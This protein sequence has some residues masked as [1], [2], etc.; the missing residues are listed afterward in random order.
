MS[1]MVRNLRDN[2]AMA[3]ESQYKNK[4]LSA[5]QLVWACRY[6]LDACW[7]VYTTLYTPEQTLWAA[8]F[9]LSTSD[10]TYSTWYCLQRLTECRARSP[11]RHHRVSTWPSPIPLQSSSVA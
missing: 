5:L 4:L 9:T 6:N 7:A 2:H 1:I 8:Q 3:E 11:A 10:Y